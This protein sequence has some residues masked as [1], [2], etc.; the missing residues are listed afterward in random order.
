M[1]DTDDRVLSTEEAAELL[2]VK[3]KT[4]RLWAK[5]GKIPAR[6]VGGKLWRFSRA[7]VLAFIREGEAEPEVYASPPSTE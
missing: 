5:T 7:Q 2:G 1:T 4:V 6:R 3:P